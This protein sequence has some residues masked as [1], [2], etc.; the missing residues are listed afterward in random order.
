MDRTEQALQE[1]AHALWATV[2]CFVFGTIA[3]VIL[4]WGDTRPFTGSGSVLLPA[5]MIAASVT[6]A[7]FLVSTLSYRRGETRPM[8]RWQAAVSNISA[9]SVTIAMGGV[10]G[11]GVLLTGQVLTAGLQGLAFGQLGGGVFT[12]VAAALGGRL[13]FQA[14][15]QLSTHDIANLLVVFLVIGTVFAMLTGTDP[16]WWEHNFSQLGVGTGAWAFNGTIVVAGLLVATIGL[17]IGRDLHRL[18]GDNALR[19]IAVVVIVWVAAGCT[20][21]AV[22]GTPTDQ[23]PIAHTIAAFTTLVLFV[24]A[25]ALTTRALARPPVVLRTVTVMVVI[26]IVVCTGLTLFL[27]WLSFTALESVVVGLVLLWL[28]TVIRVLNILVPNVSK[29]SQRSRLRWMHR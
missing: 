11:L 25:A 20:L 14:G 12:G 21:A 8:P 10:A 27:P 9:I 4:L 2:C 19:S 18:L 23:L 22:G 28:T 13:A 24:A 17:Y 15:I 5:A 7:A 29:T 26:M 16:A 6:A 3:G 1:Q